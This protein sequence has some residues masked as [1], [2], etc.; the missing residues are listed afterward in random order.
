MEGE[1]VGSPRGEA[2]GGGGISRVAE[3]EGS[4]WRR[5]Y[6]GHREGRQLV[7]GGK[8]GRREGRQLMEGGLIGSPRGVEALTFTP[9]APLVQSGP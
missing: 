4:W 1:L 3:R 8:S 7:E 2:A 5:N 9:L 6:T